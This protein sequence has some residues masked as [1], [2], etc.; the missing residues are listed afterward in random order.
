MCMLPVHIF[1]F[2]YIAWHCNQILIRDK[3]SKLKEQSFFVF[4][5]LC[6]KT[7]VRNTFPSL[8]SLV[9][10]L[11][12]WAISIC[13]VILTYSSLNGSKV[14]KNLR[15]VVRS[16]RS[17]FTTTDNFILAMSKRLTFRMPNCSL[18]LPLNP[19]LDWHS[20][21]PRKFE[22][23]KIQDTIETRW[24]PSWNKKKLSPVMRTPVYAICEQQRRRSA[25]ASAQSDQH[26]CCSLL[27]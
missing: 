5:P 6:F 17:A 19:P 14:F 15:P 2:L 4:K 9:I 1:C 20:C 16:G 3:F 12:D 22:T 18:F 8:N 27:R 24:Y 25:C 23:Y 13:G 10:G 21:V 11:S 26:L 7:V